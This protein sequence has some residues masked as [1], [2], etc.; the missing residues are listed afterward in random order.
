LE[1]LIDHG[2]RPPDSV[3]ICSVRSSQ[4]KKTTK[5]IA[6]MVERVTIRRDE[7]Q[8]SVCPL[9]K[10]ICRL[11]IHS[12]SRPKPIVS[13]LPGRAFRSHG[14]S[15]RNAEHIHTKEELYAAALRHAIQTSVRRDVAIDESLTPEEQL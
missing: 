12:T 14:G 4:I 2:A 5:V 10:T 3:R 13:M 8:S 1:Q 7:N 15:S 9:S 6:E 11:L